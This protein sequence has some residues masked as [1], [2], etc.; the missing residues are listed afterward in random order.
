MYS[1]LVGFGQN[2]NTNFQKANW[3]LDIYQYTD[4]ALYV[5]CSEAIKNL[6]ISNFESSNGNLYYL[7]ITKFGTGDILKEYEITEN[8]DFSVLNDTNEDNSINYNTPVFF[9]D[10]SNPI[11]LKF[12]NTIKKNYVIENSE[13]LKFDGSILE[14]T[15]LKLEEL[16]NKISF[17]IKIKD[18]NN[19]EYSSRI[20]L[21]IPIEKENATI[22]NGS[23]LEKKNNQNIILLKK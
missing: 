23:I 15:G 3:I 5:E 16:N 2:K 22:F 14:K 11:T 10:G 21:R 20:N 4:M 1:I 17:D 13:Q 19:D 12:V 7:D 18:Y 8:L 9:A 6:S